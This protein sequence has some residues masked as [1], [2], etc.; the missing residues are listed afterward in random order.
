LKTPGEKPSTYSSLSS[1]TA[2]SHAGG[3]SYLLLG[4]TSEKP[5]N[6]KFAEF[7]Y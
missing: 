7:Y 5:E 3:P 1:T 2:S 4:R 6:A